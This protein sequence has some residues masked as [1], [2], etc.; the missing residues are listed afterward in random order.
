MRQLNMLHRKRHRNE[1]VLKTKLTA[2]SRN[3][4]NP[5]DFFWELIA[6]TS[7][8]FFFFFASCVLAIGVNLF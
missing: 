1:S 2:K 8:T 4:L 5:D 6:R 7:M 3:L